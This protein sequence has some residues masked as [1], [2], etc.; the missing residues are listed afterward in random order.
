MFLYRTQS[1]ANKWTDDLMLS[2]RPLMNTKKRTGPRTEPWGTPDK[3]GT[4]SDTW[5]SSKL[6]VSD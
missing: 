4:G 2:G 3:T 1:S 6:V 5:L